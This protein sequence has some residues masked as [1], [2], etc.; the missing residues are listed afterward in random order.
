MMK[1]LTALIAFLMTIGSQVSAVD[2]D[3]LRKLEDTGFCQACDLALADLKGANLDG[4][5]SEGCRSGGC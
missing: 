5:R 1:H 3:D 4:C 2:P